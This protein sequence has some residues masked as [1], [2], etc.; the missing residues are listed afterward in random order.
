MITSIKA[1]D[2]FNSKL[3]GKNCDDQGCKLNDWKI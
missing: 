2:F 3:R 1:L